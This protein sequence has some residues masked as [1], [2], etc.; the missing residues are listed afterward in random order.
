M[1]TLINRWDLFWEQLVSVNAAWSGSCGITLKHLLSEP[2]SWEE[3]NYSCEQAQGP[4]F[5][6]WMLIKSLWIL[7]YCEYAWGSDVE[8]GKPLEWVTVSVFANHPLV[9][10]SNFALLNFDPQCQKF[11]KCV[12]HCNVI[13]L[14]HE[15]CCTLTQRLFSLLVNLTRF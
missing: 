6:L 15:Q 3:F 2:H 12:N 8:D 1:K 4:L 9:F 14:W 10:F 11:V 13:K 7:T 5:K